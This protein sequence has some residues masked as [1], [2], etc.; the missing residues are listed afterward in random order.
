MAI[1]CEPLLYRFVYVSEMN[2]TINNRI[3]W[4]FQPNLKDNRECVFWP[5][6]FNLYGMPTIMTADCNNTK[7]QSI[8]QLPPGPII[9][10]QS[11]TDNLTDILDQLLEDT[12]YNYTY[13]FGK[14][15]LV[16]NI[17]Y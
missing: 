4:A 8:C 12:N 9:H 14:K 17:F 5:E 1:H 16:R 2:A 10:E 7:L 13:D 3:E 6:N 11:D 15:T